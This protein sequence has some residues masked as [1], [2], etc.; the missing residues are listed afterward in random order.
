MPEPLGEDLT[1]LAALHGVATS[2]RPSPDR[3]VTA[4]AAAVTLALAALGVDAGT[5]EADP[6]RTRRPGTRTGRAAAAAD[7]GAL[8]R[9]RRAGRP[10]RPPRGHPAAD[11]DRAGRDPRLRRATPAGRPPV[12]ATAPDGRTA[13]AHLVVAPPRLPTPRR[14]LVRPARPALLPA[15]RAAPGAWATSGTSPN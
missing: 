9:R 10:R 14:T 7:R 12:T 11:R 8:E 3:T 6:C 5:P 15:L 1:R 13:D 4:S 2:Y